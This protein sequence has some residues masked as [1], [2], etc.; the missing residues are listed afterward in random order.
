MK[1]KDI[2][3]P[4]AVDQHIKKYDTALQGVINK[5]REII[6]NIDP[7][8]GE[9]IKWNSPSFFYTGDMMSFDPKEYKRDIVVLNLTKGKILMIF[10]TGATIKDVTGI[11]EGTYTDG[12]RMISIKDMADLKQ[13]E[14]SLTFVIE[15]WLKLV[16]K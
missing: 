10:P 8:V 3:N 6:L 11:L 14:A 4:Q 13:K 5:L 15:Q 2:H 16:E 9:Q 1:A 7:E 12:R